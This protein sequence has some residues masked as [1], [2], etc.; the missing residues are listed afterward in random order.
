MHRYSGQ[1]RVL[2]GTTVSG[3]PPE[4]RGAEAMVGLFINTL[5]VALAVPPLQ[6]V[7]VWLRQIQEQMSDLHLYQHSP[8]VEIQG[9][10]AI[11][12]GRP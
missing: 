9:W 1:A 10:S 2:F 8:L 12:R 4:L 11:P 5:P 6:P 7:V 3:R